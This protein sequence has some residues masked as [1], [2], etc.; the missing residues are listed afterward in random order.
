MKG[1]KNTRER[2]RASDGNWNTDL[3]F[4]VNIMDFI[5]NECEFAVEGCYSVME[6]FK[7]KLV[8]HSERTH[9]GNIQTLLLSCKSVRE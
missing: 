5:K 7:S 1:I 3:S 2:L 8:P 6:R 9:N 4:P